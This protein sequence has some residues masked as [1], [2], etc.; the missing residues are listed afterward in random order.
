[1]HRLLIRTLIIIGMLGTALPLGSATVLAD[2]AYLEKAKSYVSGLSEE[3]LSSLTAKDIDKQV[4]VDRFATLFEKHFAVKTIGRWVLGQYWRQAT[5]AE[6]AEYLDLFK[7][8]MIVNYVDRF[9]EYTG[10][11][12]K[13]V[14]AIQERENSATVFTEIVLPGGP[15]KLRVD[16]RLGSK[17]E[18]FKVVDVVVEGTS[19]SQTL[20][21]DFYSTIKREDGKVEGLL[22][23]LR[24]K[25]DNLQK[26]KAE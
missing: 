5:D 11:G 19:M 21:S 12:L 25:T 7:G 24:Q 15:E 6:K 4:R 16:W 2:D 9:A 26:A 18:T 10:D 13:I 3:A 8:L 23:A 22:K 20:R 1:M 14:K 17:D